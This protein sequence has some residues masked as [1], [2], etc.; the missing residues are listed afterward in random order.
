MIRKYELGKDMEGRNCGL[1]CGTVRCHKE[2]WP[3]AGCN[4]GGPKYEVGSWH[5]E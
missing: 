1:N 4:R 5:W 2:C 3:G